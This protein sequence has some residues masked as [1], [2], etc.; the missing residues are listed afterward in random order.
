MID[1]FPSR[2]NSK[3]SK[4]ASYKPDPDVYHVNVFSLCWLNLN[5]YIFSPFSIVGRVLAKLAQDP[6]TALVIVPC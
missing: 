5:S 6:G 3:C 4:Y 1:P 2:L